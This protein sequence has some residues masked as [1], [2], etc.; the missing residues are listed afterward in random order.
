V[1]G[2]FVTDFLSKKIASGPG[3]PGEGARGKRECDP[4]SLAPSLVA[5]SRLDR[6]PGRRPLQGGGGGLCGR[7]K[8]K[9]RKVGH[10]LEFFP[11]SRQC[12]PPFLTRPALTAGCQNPLPQRAPSSSM[13]KR[14]GSGEGGRP[15]RFGSRSVRLVRLSKGAPSTTILLLQSLSLLPPSLSLRKEERRKRGFLSS[16]VVPEEGMRR[17]RERIYAAGTHMYI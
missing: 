8:K 17:K 16:E 5:P 7:R 13:R 4:S 11:P 6:S 2:T 10:L 9:P 3:L 15:C 12:P 1:A 14:R